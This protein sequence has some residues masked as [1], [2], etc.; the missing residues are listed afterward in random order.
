VLNSSQN[1]LYALRPEARNR[2]NSAFLTAFFAGGA[3]GSALASV[4]WVHGGWTGVCVLGAILSAGT[5]ALWVLER[6][7]VNRAAAK[8]PLPR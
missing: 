3:V 6:G 4:V 1:I 8:I 7:T 2:I 5:V